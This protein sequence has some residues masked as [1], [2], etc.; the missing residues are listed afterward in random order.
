MKITAE[1]SLYPLT[2]GY[3]EKILAFLDALAR[4]DE[5]TMEVNTMSTLLTGEFD[6]IMKLIHVEL[7]KFMENDAAVFMIKL[8]NGCLIN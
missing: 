5:I 6:A 7:K 8:S 3:N 1:I 4:N 2:E